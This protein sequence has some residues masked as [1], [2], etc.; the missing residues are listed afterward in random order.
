MQGNFMYDVST[1]VSSKSD[2]NFNFL[3]NNNNNANNINNI[4]G[5][6]KLSNNTNDIIQS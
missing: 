5:N 3:N 2:L 4:N 1:S 6:N